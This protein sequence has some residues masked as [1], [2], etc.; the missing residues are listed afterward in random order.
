M[1]RNSDREAG[2]CKMGEKMHF[3]IRVLKGTLI[4]A[5]NIIPGVSGGT[6][7]VSMGIYDDIIS[8]ITNLFKKFKTSVLTLLPYAIGMLLGIIGLAYVLDYFLGKHPFQTNLLFIGLILGGIPLIWKRTKGGKAKAGKLLT[9]LILFAGIILLQIFGGGKSGTE[10]VLSTEPGQLA[11]LF[12]VGILAAATMVIPGVS[13]SMILML[14]GY[15]KPIISMVKKLV[16]ALVHFRWNM[17]WEYFLIVLP[18]AAGVII[19]IFLVAK[20]IE[21]LLEKAE[22]VTYSGI[23]GLVV[24]SPIV[25]LLINGVPSSFDSTL[26]L[27]SLATF[28]GGFFVAFLLGKE[29]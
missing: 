20:L 13:G 24:A 18:F 27:T 4:G 12:F 25:I 8:S 15:Y 22:A 7:M 21:I 3:I 5:A 1:G 19:G 29:G 16:N 23:M 10:V 26:V 9:F 2:S 11:L 6:M 14:I 28:A 17:I